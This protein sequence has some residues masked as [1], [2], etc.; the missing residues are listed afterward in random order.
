MRWPEFHFR[1]VWQ[2]QAT[3]E[4]LWPLLADTN[5]FNH[6][7]GLN[8]T[9][10]L[11]APQTNARRTLR[12]V[13]YG[14][15]LDFE[16]QP[17]EWVRP[18]RFDVRRRYFT[19]PVGDFRVQAE[20][21]PQPQG[22]TEIVYQ[23]WATPRNLLGLMAIP[24]QV[25][26]LSHQNFTATVHRYDQV[27]RALTPL[28]DL[29]ATITFAPGGRARLAAGTAAL[30]DQLPAHPHLAD[31]LADLLGH[32]DNARAARLRPYVWADRW[33]TPRQATLEAFLRA[34]RLGLLDL[35]WDLLCPLCRGAQESADHLHDLA[36]TRTVHCPTCQ[37]D[38]TA[39]FERSVELT[40]RPNPAIRSV[41]EAQ[42]CMAG[43][44]TTPHIIAQ[45]LLAPHTQRPVDVS[46]EAG[47]YRVRSLNAPGAQTFRVQASGPASAQF[48]LHAD[49]WH[50]SEP[51]VAP[52]LALTLHNATP[53]EHLL[54]VERTAWS[55]QAV[56]A[57]DVFAL[58]TFRD[59]FSSEAL[60]PSE[61]VSVGSLTVL[62]TD[63]RSSTALYREI[64]DAPAFGLVMNHFDVLKQVIDEEGGAI[65]K[66]IGDAVMAVFRQ[67]VHAVHA[68]NRA[69][70]V[71]A[72]PGE[73]GRTLSLKAGIHHGPCI[74]V[75]LNERLDYFGTTVNVAARLVEQSTGGDVVISEAVFHDPAVRAWLDN[76]PT[77]LVVRGDAAHLKGF[78]APL[79]IYR[80]GG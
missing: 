36:P 33:G 61:Q 77:P 64:G 41:S 20:L 58:Q 51:V 34:T 9:T 42:Y 27:A 80:L 14:M 1:W 10:P 47:D 3:P 74:A 69:Q 12:M 59:L 31:H 73:R 63:L 50:L 52:T 71:L 49:G 28:L 5:R 39:D 4:Q 19:G 45:F 60:R 38:F 40:F 72:M 79:P 67:P 70:I 29:P 21:H 30:K 35:R 25:G 8:T 15:A 56:I 65:V 37:I 54:L 46:L 57:A 32:E 78:D 68:M 66:T 11:A 13:F 53:T 17:F 26:V 55:D 24:V 48:A 16:E 23:V 75:T 6:D 2:V 22:G 44:Q 7:S 43:P 76:P 18:H 62:F